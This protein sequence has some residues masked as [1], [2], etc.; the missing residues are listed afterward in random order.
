MCTVLF[1]ATDL[2]NLDANGLGQL[3][4]TNDMTQT[5]T[6]LDF[7]LPTINFNQGFQAS[8]NLFT[9]AQL[10]FVP[11]IL[12][13][14]FTGGGSMVLA[15]PSVEPAINVIFSG[16]G[17][18]SGGATGPTNPCTGPV[19]SMFNCPT[20]GQQ[21]FDGQSLKPD[22]PPHPA[23]PNGEGYLVVTFGTPATGC[24]LCGLGPG[25]D[26]TF[27]ATIPEPALF[28]LLLIATG[29]LVTASRKIY[30]G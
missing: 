2:N 3:G 30:R 22:P 18:G 19:K 23:F 17:T 1:N 16:T 21:G 7:V 20:N 8:T 5:I 25:Q 14:G 28:P 15:A 4:I 27:A 9:T 11:G 26:A 12:P 10:V 13:I 29:V 24:T 6:G